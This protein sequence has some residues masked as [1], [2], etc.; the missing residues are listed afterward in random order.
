[1][2][3]LAQSRRF[4]IN[5]SAVCHVERSRDAYIL[6]FLHFVTSSAVETLIYQYFSTLSRRAQS[7]RFYINNSPLCHVERSRD[8]FILMLL[9]YVTSSAV[10]TLIQNL[11][12][13]IARHFQ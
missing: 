8:A 5:A 11:Q 10:E 6:M 13:L 7:R 2:S 4:Y 12:K 3:R 1:M 9:Q